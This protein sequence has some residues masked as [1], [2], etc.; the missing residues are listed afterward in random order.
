MGNSFGFKLL[1]FLAKLEICI[2]LLVAFYTLNND[3]SYYKLKHSDAVF[4]YKA[5]F[6]NF[7]PYKLDH[8]P[9]ETNEVVNYIVRNIFMVNEKD[10]RAFILLVKISIAFY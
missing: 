8:K 2:D 5:K 4:V 7:A 6:H 9:R 3:F 1:P 10:W